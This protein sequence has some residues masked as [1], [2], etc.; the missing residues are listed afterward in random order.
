MLGFDFYAALFGGPRD[1]ETIPQNSAT[2]TKP[3]VRIELT[4]LRP[5]DP[6][7]AP[8]YRRTVYAGVRNATGHHAAINGTGLPTYHYV[9]EPIWTRAHPEPTE[10]GTE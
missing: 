4:K 9:Y 5:D 2:S 6:C 8:V 1:G 7:P 10:E 3:P